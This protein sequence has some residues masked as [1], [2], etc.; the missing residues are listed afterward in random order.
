MLI[1]ILLP[2]CCFLIT[3]VTV[4]KNVH[5]LILEFVNM[6][7]ADLI[8]SWDR[9]LSWS[10]GEGPMQILGSLVRETG[11]WESEEFEWRWSDGIEARVRRGQQPR[12]MGSLWKLEK[13]KKW[14]LPSNLQ[15]EHSPADSFILSS[16]KRFQISGLQNCK[17]IKLC[18]F[19]PLRL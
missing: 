15:N 10:I 9:R 1:I 11:G 12:N 4:P 7:L 8:K 19:K 17:I 16:W 3:Y 6:V 5:M 2:G 13:E 14:L 18:R